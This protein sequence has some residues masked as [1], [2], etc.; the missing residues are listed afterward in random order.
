[1]DPFCQAGAPVARDRGRDAGR[2]RLDAG[3]DEAEE[4]VLGEVRAKSGT[5]L[6]NA[7]RN[8]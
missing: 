1:V 8:M 3:G 2:R 4:D 5:C 7:A 6:R